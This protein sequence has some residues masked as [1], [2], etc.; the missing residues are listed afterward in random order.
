MRFRA[1]KIVQYLLDR[2]P[3]DMNHLGRVSWGEGFTS[4]DWDQFNQLIGYSVS[5]YGDLSYVS[6][7]EAGEC[8]RQAQPE[9]PLGS[10]SL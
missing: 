10:P 2:G 1:N 8:D 5:G 6:P 7:E 3:V 9:P 4:D